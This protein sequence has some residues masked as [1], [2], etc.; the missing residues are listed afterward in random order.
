MF[1][2]SRQDKRTDHE[3]YLEDE[4]ERAHEAEERRREGERRDR[5]HRHTERMREM[6]ERMRE[7]ADWPDALRQQAFLC[8]RE[9]RKYSP[10]D[11]SDIE[12]YF[13][14]C[15]QISERA[16]ELWNAVVSEQQVQQQIDAIWDRVRHEVAARLTAKCS[17]KEEAWIIEA[18]RNNELEGFLDL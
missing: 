7:A 9:H 17:T 4:L 1:A 5:E 15:A 14:R 12:H 2:L 18:I 16:L 8:W 3:R 13:E 11:D 6:E 10:E